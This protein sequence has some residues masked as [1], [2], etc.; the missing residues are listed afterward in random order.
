MVVW[1]KC[2][3]VI[4][5]PFAVGA[6]MRYVYLKPFYKWSRLGPFCSWSGDGILHQVSP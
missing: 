6:G 5:V 1:G 2:G 3:K 4:E